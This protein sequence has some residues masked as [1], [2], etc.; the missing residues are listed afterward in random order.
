MCSFDNNKRESHLENEDSAD[1]E[2]Q[3]KDYL[4]KSS[5]YIKHY[6]GILLDPYR[7]C[8]IFNIGGGPREHIFKKALRGPDKGHSETA[9]VK[10]LKACVLRWEQLLKEDNEWE[11]E[12]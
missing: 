10:E 6:Q 11:D 3:D 4:Q 12:D 9:L 8:K 7:L 5:H 1:L 2:I